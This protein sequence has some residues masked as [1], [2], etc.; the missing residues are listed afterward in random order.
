MPADLR[1]FDW[2]GLLG[3]AR[4]S[5]HSRW[6]RIAASATAVLAV[7]GLGIAL[8]LADATLYTGGYPGIHGQVA[9]GAVLI[10]AVV[11]LVP[12]PEFPDNIRPARRHNIIRIHRYIP[13]PPPLERA[14]SAVVHQ[15]R[16]RMLPV[17]DP[18]PDE[19]EPIREPRA[20]LRQPRQCQSAGSWRE[21]VHLAV[22]LAS[23]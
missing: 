16:K 19:L 23:F 13:P 4:R 1:S 7:F 5:V 6:F 14:T 3:H 8:Q 15:P 18:T 21:I 20:G 11:L 2:R 12:L 17:P 10:H 22:F 9:V